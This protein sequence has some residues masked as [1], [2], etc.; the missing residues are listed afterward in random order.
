VIY[1][2]NPKLITFLIL[3]KKF[4][5]TRSHEDPEGE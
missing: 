2:Y 1:D 3:K 4:Y 5:L